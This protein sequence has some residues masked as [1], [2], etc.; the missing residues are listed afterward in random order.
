MRI[1]PIFFAAGKRFL[2]K[3]IVGNLEKFQKLVGTEV[4]GGLFRIELHELT[5]RFGHNSLLQ[6]V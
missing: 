4:L 6:S 3:Y 1:C 5:R 2:D